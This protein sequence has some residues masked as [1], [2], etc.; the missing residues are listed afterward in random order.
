MSEFV[1]RKQHLR[2]VLF[3]HYLLKKDAVETWRLLM[4][5]YDFYTPLEHADIG[6]NA[7]KVVISISMTK[8]TMV[9]QNKEFEELPDIEPCQTVEELS[10]AFDVDLSTVEKRL[11]TLGMVQKAGNWVPHELERDIETRLVTRKMLIQRICIGSS[12]VMKNG[13]YYDNF[14]HELAWIKPVDQGP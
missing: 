12:L 5:A 9:P 8:N 2:E 10:E 3:H 11:H 6:F 13:F 14:K 1:P 7:S 4:N